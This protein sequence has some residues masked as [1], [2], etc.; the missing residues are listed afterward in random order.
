MNYLGI[1][2]GP[3]QHHLVITEEEQ[4]MIVNALTFFHA[5]FNPRRTDAAVDI[6]HEWQDVARDTSLEHMD[7][8]A[9]QVAT[10]DRNSP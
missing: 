2:K 10:L 9:T 4:N 3:T 5:M 1:G 6:Y 7:K 8:L